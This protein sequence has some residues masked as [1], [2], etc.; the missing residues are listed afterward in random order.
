[1]GWVLCQG[2]ST[3]G[4]P[5]GEA[6]GRRCFLPC[7]VPTAPRLQVLSSRALVIISPESQVRLSFTVQNAIMGPRQAGVAVVFSLPLQG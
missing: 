3:A 5:A 2:S 6:V 4:V 1:M 7:S